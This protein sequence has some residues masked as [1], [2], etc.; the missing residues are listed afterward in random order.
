MLLV[1]FCLEIKTQ[2]LN[3]PNGDE[4]YY[5]AALDL[6]THQRSSVHVLQNLEFA[7]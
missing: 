4:M 6:N 2:P 7:C 1:M 5:T 3:I